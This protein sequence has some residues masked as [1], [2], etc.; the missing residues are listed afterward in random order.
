[1]KWRKVYVLIF[2]FPQDMSSIWKTTGRGGAAKVK[3]FPCAVTTAT[4]VTLQ[5]KHK[6][7]LGNRCRMSKCYHHDMLTEATLQAWRE[8]K[9]GL[10]E[11]YPYLATPPLT[12]KR[13]R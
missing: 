9:Q 1:M 11:E 13:H 2:F 3:T 6:C 10:E 4:L 7:F 12:Y 5:P 8:Q